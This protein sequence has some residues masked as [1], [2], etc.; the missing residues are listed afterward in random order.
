MITGIVLTKNASRTI[1]NCLESLDFCDEVLIVDDYSTDDTLSI[2]KKSKAKVITR[3]VDTDFAAQRNFALSHIKSGWALFVDADEVVTPE[4]AK[5]ITAKV[6]SESPQSYKIARVDFMWGKR[7]THGETGNT[8]LVR[9]AKFDAGLWHGQVHEYWVTQNP[10]LLRNAIFHYPHPT[11]YE[12]L[13]KINHYS[14]LKAQQFK[15]QGRSTNIF[16]IT[17]GP[18]WRFF[19]NYIL[20]LGFLDGTVGFIHAGI[21]A[22]Y[23]FL[24]AAKLWLLSH[25]S[26]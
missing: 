24:V 5:E 21:M 20:K 8:K 1:S 9:L 11:L 12:F 10:G 2:A 19:E 16:E 7:L 14:T 4:L 26:S 6:K 22:F 18:G 17:L 15:S 25:P 3:A 23:M 13:Q